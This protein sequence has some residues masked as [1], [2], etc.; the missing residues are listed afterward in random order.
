MKRVRALLAEFDQGAEEEARN[1]VLHPPGADPPAPDAPLEDRLL[2]V[3]AGWLTPTAPHAGTVLRVLGDPDGGDPGEG[4]GAASALH[5]TLVHAHRAQE[6]LRTGRFGELMAE[7][8]AAEAAAPTTSPWLSFRLGSI[9]QTAFRFS[10]DP[11]LAAATQRQ[12]ARAA[13]HL[14]NP[15]LAVAARGL[16]GN[17][18]MLEG[19]LHRA[20]EHFQAALELADASGLQDDPAPAMAHQFQGYVLLEWNRLP[21]AR[22]ALLRAWRAS[23]EGRRRGVGSGVA[24]V[25]AG[26]EAVE[27]RGEEADAWLTRLRD[28]LGPQASLRN[29]E[30]L[31]AV[32]ARRALQRGDRRGATE[33]LRTYDY[34]P[35]H[36]A[37][38]DDPEVHARLEEFTTCLDFLVETE[39]WTDAA[40]VGER[41]FR[42]TAGKRRWFAARAGVARAAALEALGE[43]GP[44]EEAL[45]RALQEGEEGS[46]LRCFALAPERL[47][48]VVQRLARRGGGAIPRL[49]AVE[50]LLQTEAARETPPSLTPREREVMALVARG[51][52]NKAIGKEL[53]IGLGTVKS[54]VHNA[55]QRLG[56]S[57]R[58]EAV[59]RADALGLLRTSV[60]P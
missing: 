57:S 51:L 56:A 18:H 9:L 8:R 43:P 16:M 24:R 2:W 40:A 33:W 28:M 22:A 48:P 53:G 45:R 36:I 25:M 27:G 10:G 47:L 38:L 54:H 55:L 41:L 37:A 32:L 7:A 4:A 31:A 50:A 19:R 3:L 20:M 15:G 17:V 49:R 60:P 11:G 1:G 13:D 21:E 44:A 14:A 30:W 26:L 29:R 34:A 5:R 12:L 46:L 35:A 59:S 23:G 6:S 58:T 52:S 42:A 39:G